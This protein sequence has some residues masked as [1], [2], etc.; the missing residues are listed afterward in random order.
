MAVTVRLADYEDQKDAATIVALLDLYARDPM[1]GGEPLPEYVRQNLVPGLRAQAGAF[2][3]IASVNG[4]AAGLANCIWGFSS[5]S[6]RRLLN[7][8]DL[9]VDPAFRGK[10]AAKAL[11]A[12]IERIAESGDACKVTL[13]V[14]SGNEPAKT[15][16]SSLGY[17]DYMLDPD[18]G[19]ALCWQKRLAA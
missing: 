9:I 2:S 19:T 5:F 6:A 15:L 11:F 13:E 3:L 7:I 1:G 18:K 14:L 16:Y 8:H 12:E 10:G 4:E 17:G